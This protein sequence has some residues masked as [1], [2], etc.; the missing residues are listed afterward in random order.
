MLG[1]GFSV[2]S[3]P[4]RQPKDK[5]ICVREEMKAVWAGKAP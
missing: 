5:Q 4:H 3:G 1:A 2:V